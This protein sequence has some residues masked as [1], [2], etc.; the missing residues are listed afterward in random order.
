[1]S[2]PPPGAPLGDVPAPDAEPQR[3]PPP[4][5]P[6]Q[7]RP[8][9]GLP[10]RHRK[11]RGGPG[12]A[13]TRSAD[14]GR[15]SLGITR[16][17]VTSDLPDGV[18]ALASADRST[19]FVSASLDHKGRRAAIRVVLRATHRFPGLALY[20]ALAMARIRRLLAE[21]G[22][23]AAGLIQHAASLA[24]ASP[25]AGVVVSVVTVA[26]VAAATVGLVTVTQPGSPVPVSPSA[27]TSAPWPRWH[28]VVRIKIPAYPDSYLGVYAGGVPRSYA[29]VES[30][31]AAAGAQPDIALYYSG[32]DEPFRASFALAAAEHDA[33]PLVQI[34]PA[35]ASLAGIADGRYDH[36]LDSFA[37]AVA[38]YGAQTGQGVIIG[39]GHEPNA[40]WYPWGWGH[41]S[42]RAWV[43]AWRHIVDVFRSSGADDVT[44]LWT[45]NRLGGVPIQDYWPGGRYVTWVGID[46][47]YRHG[48]AT[49]GGVFGA[50]VA[51]VRQ[52]TGDPVLLSETA[53]PPG[54]HQAGQIRELFRGVVADKLLGFVWFDAASTR[55][56]ALAAGTPAAAAFRRAARGI[57]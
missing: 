46:G 36:C 26:G 21:T 49:F 13:A 45:I 43:R 30:F 22:E 9:E 53:A 15:R 24:A 34:D 7:G 19:V 23:A 52:L 51:A 4:S 6:A 40:T 2:M 42:P 39:F 8:A 50:T 29:P 11:A 14:A 3:P 18:D 31:A 25:A 48:R 17:A 20:P 16:I 44:W 28:R 57:L 37:A 1:M 27:T 47:Y 56:W 5:T 38:S 12:R 32:W 41:A 10:A 54:R 35:G 33:V 55:D